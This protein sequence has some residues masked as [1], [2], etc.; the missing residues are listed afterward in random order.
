MNKKVK[1]YLGALICLLVVFSFIML[2]ILMVNRNR[3]EEERKSYE[4]EI[5]SCKS[6]ISELEEK[7]GLSDEEFI[8][9]QKGSVKNE[10]GNG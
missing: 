5:E 2:I 1:M 10:N 3:F 9:D 7:L 4:A 6:R 8:E